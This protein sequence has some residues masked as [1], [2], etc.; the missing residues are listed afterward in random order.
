MPNHML[1]LYNNKPNCMFKFM[2]N[3]INHKTKTHPRTTRTFN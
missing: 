1:K 2:L 3:F